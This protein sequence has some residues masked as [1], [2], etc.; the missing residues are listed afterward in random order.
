MAH[1]TFYCDS[2]LHRL[3]LC[4]TGWRSW[5]TVCLDSCRRWAIN[6]TYVC[7]KPG[8][9][10]IRAT[11]AGTWTFHRFRSAV[12]RQ[13][14]DSRHRALHR[15]RCGIIGSRQRQPSDRNFLR[16]RRRRVWIWRT[17]TSVWIRHAVA[18]WTT[19]AISRPRRPRPS[20]DPPTAPSRC[21]RKMSSGRRENATAT[22]GTTATTSGR[23]R[24]SRTRRR[25]RIRPASAAASPSSVSAVATV[26]VS[27]AR[28]TLPRPALDVPSNSARASAASVASS[29]FADTFGRRTST[30]TTATTTTTRARAVRAG[31]TVAGAGCY[32]SSC[33][34]ACHA[35]ASTGRCAASSGRA[36]A[37][38]P[39]GGEP[40]EVVTASSAAARRSNSVVA[41]PRRRN[42]SSS[43]E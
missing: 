16:L 17:W 19:T 12:L 26:D 36:R 34:S 3:L 29:P 2:E 31:R 32:S 25:C 1:F 22:K 41:G 14:T 8:T 42:P 11:A 24:T 38:R 23:L 6:T 37:V 30:S 21:R 18:R 10:C 43:S 28:G 13:S 27:C 15:C 40:A 7:C 5:A 9:R 33:P 39:A 20:A 4:D 35:S